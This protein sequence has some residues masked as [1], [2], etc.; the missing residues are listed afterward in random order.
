MI[1]D[2]F[3]REIIIGDTIIYTD[4]ELRI[5]NVIGFYGK[6][7]Y[8]VDTTSLGRRTKADCLILKRADGTVYFNND[9]L[10]MNCWSTNYKDIIVL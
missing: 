9:N 5:N 4:G 1:K 2:I 7:Y 10:P 3:G 8:I 6:T